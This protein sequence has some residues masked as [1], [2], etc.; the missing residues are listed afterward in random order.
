MAERPQVLFLVKNLFS[1]CPCSEA[2]YE[3]KFKS[4]KLI[5]F[6]EHISSKNSFQVVAW[7]LLAVFSQ[8]YSE[9]WEQEEEQKYL[10]DLQFQEN[11]TCKIGV[12]EG[13]IAEKISTI[14]EKISTFF[15][16]DNRKDVLETCQKLDLL[17]QPQAQV[18]TSIN[19][20]VRLLFE[21]RTPGGAP[22]SHRVILIAVSLEFLLQYSTIQELR[23]C[24]SHGPSGSSYCYCWQ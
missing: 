4:Y 16:R 1:F 20:F 21:N 9:N 8:V 7:V 15:N 24:C 18:Y 22:C 23:G 19:L 3:A 2:L 6:V 12:K 11:S 10:K 14:K 17:Y 13:V 5:Y